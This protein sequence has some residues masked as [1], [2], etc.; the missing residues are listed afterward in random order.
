MRRSRLFKRLPS[1]EAIRTNRF[2]KP[3]AGL[4][5]HHFLWQFNRRSVAR[6]V[7]VGLFFGIMFPIAQ[8]LLAALAAIVLRVNLPVAAFSTLVSN[9][10]TFPP[11]YYAAYRLGALLTGGQTVTDETVIEQEVSERLIE[12]QADV[13]GWF[14]HLLDWLQTVGWPLLAGLA[15]LAILASIAGYFLVSAAWRWH[16][17]HRWRKRHGMPPRSGSV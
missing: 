17:I 5:H 13:A 14:S 6:G 9:P 11:L 16:T 7:A 15:T 10:L 1:A 4:L 3:F 8:I 12:Q 2:L